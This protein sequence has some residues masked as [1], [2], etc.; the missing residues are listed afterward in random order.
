MTRCVKGGEAHDF[1][2]EDVTGVHCPEHGVT[3]L[4]H[5]DRH[6]GGTTEEQ[7]HPA[8]ERGRS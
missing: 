4:W 7:R 2:I 5:T 8:P 3:I 1:P 6:P